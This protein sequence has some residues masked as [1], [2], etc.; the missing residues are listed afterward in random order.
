MA[1]EKG[2]EFFHGVE[3]SFPRYGKRWGAVLLAAAVAAGGAGCRSVKASRLAVPE[4]S[5]WTATASGAAPG[6]EAAQ[7]LDGRTDTW[8]RSGAAE[9]QWLQV[10]LGRAAMV[11]GVSLQWGDP[12]ATA[13]AVQT[14]QDGVH[15]ARGYQTQEGDGDWDQVLFEPILARQV[16]VVVERGLQGTGAA[17]RA[18]EV[19]GL[20]GRPQI[21]VDGVPTP[22]ALALLDGDAATSWRSRS[23]A[24]VLEMDLR[25]PRAIGSVRVDWGA[26]GYASN[27]MVEVSTNRT[28]WVGAGQVQARAGDFDVVMGE[29]GHPAQFARV[30]FAGGSAAEGFEVTGLTLRGAEGR[31]RPWASYE[32]AAAQA[33][34]GVYPEVFRRRQAYWAAAGARR[35]GEAESL[36]DE[37]GGFSAGA[38]HPTLSPLIV[39]GEGVATAR[40]AVKIEHR[41]AGEGTPLPE[42][43]WRLASGL[44]LRIRAMSRGG[45]SPAMSWASYELANE[46]I[47]VQTGRLAWVARPVSVPPPWAGGGLAPIFRVRRM[48]T[49]GGWQ[50]MWMNGRCGW[51]MADP[52]LGFGAAPFAGGDVAE[53]F[54]RGET[55]PGRSARDEEGLASAAWWMDFE[56]PPGERVRRVVACPAPEGEGGNGRRPAWPDGT[57]GPER[58]AD[59][60]EREWGDATWAWRAETEKYAPHID[61]PEA[62]DCLQAQ[63]GWLL[64]VRRTGY[65]GQEVETLALGAAALLRAGQAEAARAWIEPVAAGVAADGW[66]PAAFGPE[67]A[68]AARL[69]MGGRHG[70]QGQFAFLVMEYYRFTQDAAFLHAHY[71]AMRAALRY[72][73]RLRGEQE[74]AEWRLP[75][76]ER[77]LLEGLLPLSDARAGQPRPA[78]VYADHYWAL[79]GWK[80]L[81]AAASLLGLA[82]D[83]AWADEEYRRLKAAVKRSLRAHLDRRTTSWLPASAEED[84]LDPSSVALLFWP[85]GETDLAEPHELQSSL[86]QFYEGFLQRGGSGSMPSDEGLL[87]GPLA[88]MGRGDYAREVLYALLDRRRPAGWQAWADAMPGEARQPGLA[89]FMPDRR[90]AAGYV[91]GVRGL[92]AREAGRRLDLF[93]GAPAEWLQHGEGFQVFGMPTAF[94]PLDLRGTW[95]RDRMVV[96]IGGQ[97][98]PPEGYRIWWPRTAAPTRV[99]ANGAHLMDYDALGADLPHDFKGTVEAVFPYLAPWPRDP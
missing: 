77:E 52:A 41:L 84:R 55:P 83:A 25:R 85:C 82:E 70:S 1:W 93:S 8:W 26:L 90:A 11:C 91:I 28:A 95:R 89:G 94:G 15:W 6:F 57:G 76:E 78:H 58:V 51:A 86:D 61:R 63:V 60:F 32:L 31:A 39:T 10:D 13:Y 5:R 45:T 54:L 21:R 36:L 50:E 69:G 34:E 71:P 96:E 53:F 64:G 75:A 66:V 12:H 38:R 14:S 48:E 99:L 67:G 87:L 43:V 37:G 92:A 79:L 65:G 68:A 3:K 33:R 29:A 88:Q 7:A 46:S 18:L 16:R 62:I 80:E 22:A 40:Q 23:A 74:K 4:P 42:V 30:P 56:L 19:K 47:M 73:Q 2:P 49:A 35:P 98:S 59:A 20:A 81:R 9:P 72:L 44:V 27:V 97:A 17:L 24:A